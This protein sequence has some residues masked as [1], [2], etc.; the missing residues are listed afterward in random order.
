LRDAAI[1]FGIVVCI[2]VG[3]YAYTGLWPPL[4][5]VESNSMQHDTD[6]S[7]VGVIDTGD[8]VLVKKV[9]R[10]SEVRTYVD[11][12]ASGHRTYGDYGDVVVYK[13]FG[14]DAYTPIIHR[15]IIYLQANS[16]G[17]SYSAPSLRLLPSDMWSVANE[18]DT[19]LRLTSSL[20]LRD[21]GQD[22]D[23]F[24]RSIDITISI[25]TII[26]Q[27]E[28]EEPDLPSGFITMGDHN[29]VT[30]Q[31]SAHGVGMRLVETDWV[32]GKARGEIPWFGL[33]KLWFTDSLGS[34]APANSVRNLWIS[35]A[36]IVILPV[37]VDVAVTYNEKRKIA[38]RR[39]QEQSPPDE[40]P[41]EA[42]KEE[43]QQEQPPERDG[44]SPPDRP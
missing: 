41:E 38:A 19:W 12:I 33:L 43:H 36:L 4:V 2:L 42:D 21:I 34:E 40:P 31:Q 29:D 44:T 26:A 5:V 35:V 9:D 7:Y 13:K 10:E 1:A 8:L 28:D 15:A 22:Q 20:T 16:D 37:V 17:R 3:M 14:S 23:P 11:G 18:E 39:H 30:D 27:Y 32:V 6:R 24:Y 25:S